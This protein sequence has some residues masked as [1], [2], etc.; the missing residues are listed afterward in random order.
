MITL[1]QGNLRERIAEYVKNGGI[2]VTGPMTDIRTADGTRFTDRYHG[3]LETLTPAKW[4]YWFPDK[5]KRVKAEWKNKEDFGGNF[6]YEIFEPNK[7]ADMVNVADGHKAI[8]DGAVLQCYRVGKGYVYVLGT[9]PDQKDMKKLLS[10]VCQKANI[11]Y[12]IIEDNSIIVSPR[13]GKNTSGVMLLDVSGKG[14]VYHNNIKYKDIISDRV[15]E[16]DITVNP[17]E[18][19]VLEKI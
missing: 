12:N 16:D 14:G 11:P 2:W 1:D 3:M 15:F 17:Y 4:K 13:V 6:Y 19:M 18:V 8:I 7:E 10:I 5:E 9:L